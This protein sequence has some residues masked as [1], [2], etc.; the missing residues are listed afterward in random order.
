[1]NHVRRD[2]AGL[3]VFRFEWIDSA[4]PGAEALTLDGRDPLVGGTRPDLSRV[5]PGLGNRVEGRFWAGGQARRQGAR[6][7]QGAGGKAIL[8]RGG[9][10]EKLRKNAA[11]QKKK[12]GGRIWWFGVV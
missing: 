6:V 7:A 2:R 10:E 9:G 12:A 3:G 4:S 8:K 1:V 11:P 5:G